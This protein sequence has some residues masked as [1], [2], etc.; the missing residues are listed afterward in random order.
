MK[1]GLLALVV[2]AAAGFAQAQTKVGYVDVQKAIQST[3]AGK[4]AK[5]LLD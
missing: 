3:A 2:M 1:K 5:D 4:K